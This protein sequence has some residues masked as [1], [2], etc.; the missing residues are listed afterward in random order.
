M[1]LPREEQI[2]GVSGD[3]GT[4]H[5]EY[6]R[7]GAAVAA[8]WNTSAAYW[9]DSLSQ[10][11]SDLNLIFASA[12]H[13][14]TGV[15]Y[16]YQ[17][18]TS[19]NVACV[20][21]G[22]APP[23]PPTPPTPP[24]TPEI[25]FDRVDFLDEASG[26][27]STATLTPNFGQTPTGPVTWTILSVQNPSAPWWTRGSGDMNGLTWGPQADGLSYWTNTSAPEGT[28]PTGAVA[29]LTDVVGERTV[30]VRA[31]TTIGGTLIERDL[32]VTFGKGPLS[33]FSSTP[34]SSIIFGT[35]QTLTDFLTLNPNSS[36]DFP[37][38]NHCGG[39]VPVD[40]IS[41][42]GS[43]P[44]ITVTVDPSVW[45]PVNT[46]PHNYSGDF[47]ASDM[48]KLPSDF[49]LL[50][51]S[52]NT[53]GYFPG[54]PTKGAA[55]AAGWDYVNAYWLNTIAIYNVNTSPYVNIESLYIETGQPL[56]LAPSPI[57]QV[58][59]TVCVP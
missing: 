15:S 48:I 12:R 41:S 19:Q 38:A 49:Q 4:S 39:I 25:V 36:T 18:N 55:L 27:Q 44:N 45:T 35:R 52:R 32:V 47:Y 40:R 1:G 59:N 2:L 24:A 42:T 43:S 13:V 16:G 7:K 8:G 26:F 3:N 33:V 28:A 17:P 50:Y 51:V 9:Y 31:E 14:D 37:A 10:N 21:V 46:N 23:T 34:S 20:P 30:T 54:I 29:E 11:T 57:S 56:S 5:Q 22:S 6:P 53:S 58:V